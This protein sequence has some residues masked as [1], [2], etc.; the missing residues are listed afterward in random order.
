MQMLNLNIYSDLSHC[1]AD[2]LSILNF[3]GGLPW[4][5]RGRHTLI[6]T[7]GDE[8][9][10]SPFRCTHEIQ[11]AGTVRELVHLKRIE[12]ENVLQELRTMRH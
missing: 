7:N 10:T 3:A 6:H 5:L 4:R 1:N 8:A 9:G 2:K 11:V 12:T